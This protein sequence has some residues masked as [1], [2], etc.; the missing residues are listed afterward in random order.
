MINVGIVSILFFVFLVG[1]IPISFAEEDSKKI[2]W[3]KA[4]LDSKYF[5][6]FQAQTR[7]ADGSLVSVVETV[8]G[9]YLSDSRTDLAY[10]Q[11]PLVDASA[12]I[13]NK[14]YEMRELV[15]SMGSIPSRNDIVSAFNV[16]YEIDGEHVAVFHAFPPFILAEYS[17]IV[18]V[19]WTIFKKI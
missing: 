8:H 5:I 16:G 2:S 17:D 1:I 9:E 19:Q 10:S 7:N 11:L 14:K 13:L 15:V 18:T 3:E 6:H 12:E 4:T